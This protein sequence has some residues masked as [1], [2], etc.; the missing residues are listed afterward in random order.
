MFRFCSRPKK[1][2][3]ELRAVVFL[4]RPLLKLTLYCCVS[5]VKAKLEVQITWHRRTRP[6]RYLNAQAL[7]CGH[8][9][10]ESD[11]SQL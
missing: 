8:I 7:L 5:V 2:R 4:R 1:I 10:S 6:T 11:N 3:I 9:S